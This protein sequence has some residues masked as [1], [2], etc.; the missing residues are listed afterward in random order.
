M[1]TE[2]LHLPGP[3]LSSEDTAVS[4]AEKVTDLMEIAFDLDNKK[5]SKLMLN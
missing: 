3:V 2:N 1:Y 4:K 5:E